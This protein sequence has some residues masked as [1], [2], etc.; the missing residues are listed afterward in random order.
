[1]HLALGL[2]AVLVAHMIY[3][4]T[5]LDVFLP[6][7]AVTWTLRALA[8]LTVTCAGCPATAVPPDQVR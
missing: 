3:T 6:I 2:N 1:M 4:A 8:L 5:D 7:E